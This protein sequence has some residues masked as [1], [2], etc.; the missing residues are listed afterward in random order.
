MIFKLSAGDSER[1]FL[2]SHPKVCLDIE[3][4]PHLL[5]ITNEVM[6][7]RSAITQDEARLDIKA[8][9]FWQSIVGQDPMKC[10][11]N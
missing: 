1:R 7:Y 5:P 11:I 9:N 6:N 8:R 2:V 3:S 10:F 4:E